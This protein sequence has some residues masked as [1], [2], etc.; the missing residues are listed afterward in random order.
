MRNAPPGHLATWRGEVV[1]IEPAGSRLRGSVRGDLDIVAEVTT[2]AA[3]TWLRSAE[4]W[5]AVKASEIE[6]YPA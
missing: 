2:E 1:G 5:V 6:T 4:V 3:E